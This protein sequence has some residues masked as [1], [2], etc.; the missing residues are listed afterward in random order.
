MSRYAQL[1]SVCRRRA[2]LK[3][4]PLTNSYRMKQTSP[5]ACAGPA[6]MQTLKRTHTRTKK[7]SFGKARRVLGTDSFIEVPNLPLSLPI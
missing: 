6:T 5:R 3:I 7:G 2:Y 1:D 4:H